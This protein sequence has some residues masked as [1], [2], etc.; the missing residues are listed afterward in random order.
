MTLTRQT[1]QQILF[2]AW[3]L[4]ARDKAFVPTPDAF[5]DCDRLTEA[6]WLECRTVDANGD[7]AFRWTRQAELALDVDN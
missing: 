3:A 1:E 2:Q 7:T 6:G 4:H 5:P